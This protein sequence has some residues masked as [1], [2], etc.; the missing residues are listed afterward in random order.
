VTEVTEL[1]IRWGDGNKAAL[2]ELMPLVYNE[3]RK[4]ARSYARGERPDHTLNATALVNEA[5]IRLAGQ[6]S[7]QWQNRAHFYGIAAQLMR[8]VLIDHA[9]R[10][11][12]DKRGGGE[13][14]IAFEDS[15]GAPRQPSELLALDDAL[16]SF[17]AIDER[18]ARI[19]E[20]RQFGGLSIDEV[21]EV[22]HISPATVKR[23]WTAAKAWLKREIEGGVP[24]A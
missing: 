15:M 19:V 14:P 13:V 16:K 9:R 1:L 10:K 2:D 8:R 6:R 22:M 5:Y 11:R 7:T 20:L 4:L 21:A 12:S 17:A 3:L 24:E 18:G 23:E